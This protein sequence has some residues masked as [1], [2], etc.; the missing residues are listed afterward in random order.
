M[1]KYL[2]LKH[3]TKTCLFAD[4]SNLQ[5]IRN[6]LEQSSAIVSYQSKRCACGMHSLMNKET[7]TRI[8]KHRTKTDLVISHVIKHVIRRRPYSIHVF[9]EQAYKC[10]AVTV[11]LMSASFISQPPT[12]LDHGDALAAVTVNWVLTTYLI[13][14]TGRTPVL[15]LVLV[16]PKQ[17]ITVRET[18]ELRNMPL[19]LVSCVLA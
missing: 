7:R 18:S 10:L 15:N 5:V 16:S 19:N 2:Q 6:R 12:Y 9:V 1:L 13:S 11:T 4:N 17:S 3:P 8:T 14:H